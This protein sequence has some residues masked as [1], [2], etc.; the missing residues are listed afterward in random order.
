MSRNGQMDMPLS[1]MAGLACL[2]CV[3]VIYL[4]TRPVV[5]LTHE[6]WIAWL[7]MGLFVLVPLSVTFIVLYR[8]GWH[9]ERPKWKRIL[10]TIFSSCVILGVDLIAVGALLAAACLL[11]G[12]VRGH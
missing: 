7:L 8:G 2:F 4:A 10:S 5:W 12:I 6:Q 9:E 1:L 3:P 11:S